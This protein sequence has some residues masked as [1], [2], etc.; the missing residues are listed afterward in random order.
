VCAERDAATDTGARDAGGP[1]VVDAATADAPADATTADAALVDAALAD[2][3]A[4]EAA[5]GCDAGLVA[6]G[7]TCV[8][9]SSDH[10]HCGTCGTA[11]ALGQT[12]CAGSCTSTD[13]DSTN[14]GGCGNACAV[15]GAIC[16]GGTC[17]CNPPRSGSCGVDEGGVDEGGVDEGGVDEGGATTCVDLTSDTNHCGAC[18]TAC[19]GATPVCTNGTCAAACN[20]ASGQTQCGTQCVTLGSDVANCG[21]CGHACAPSAECSGGVCTPLSSVDSSGCADG[22]REVFADATTFPAIAA[23]AGGWDGNGNS[24]GYSGVFPAPLR[25]QAANCAQNGNSGPNPRGIGCSAIDLCAT[26][27]HICGGGEVLAG[28]RGAPNFDAQTDGCLADTWPAGSFFAAAIGSTGCL[29]CAEPNGTVTGPTCT[30]ASCAAGCQANPGLTNDVFG[31]G[32]GAEAVNTCGDVDRT[33]NDLC[34]YLDPGWS[35]GTDDVRESVNL[36]HDPSPET[37]PSP[38]GVLCCR[39][40]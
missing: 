22:T 21:A 2:A 37:G 3:T 5:S 26:G 8:D 7:A 20:T 24:P 18:G 9:L 32:A 27:W 19:S 29:N 13:V 34:E 12:C 28:V 17:G 25:T 10:D 1:D 31:C 15:A 23:C 6:C 30:N 36:V 38:G 40:Q 11:C 4:M 16:H 14:C 35:C 39:D 33:G